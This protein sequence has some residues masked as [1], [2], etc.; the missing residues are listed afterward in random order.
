VERLAIC[1]SSDPGCTLTISY[2]KGY[3]AQDQAVAQAG[4][5]LPSLADIEDIRIERGGRL[6]LLHVPQFVREV[7]R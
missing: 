7:T 4:F 1:Q 6:V 2:R 5:E 3:N